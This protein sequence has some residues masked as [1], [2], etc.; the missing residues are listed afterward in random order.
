MIACLVAHDWQGFAQLFADDFRMS[1][2]R[3]VVQLELDRD[4]YVAFTREVADGRTVRG[5]SELLATRGERLAL[6]RSTFEFTDADVGPSEIAFLILTEVDARG[7]IVAYVRFDLDDLDAAYAELDA[8][9]AGR[10]GGEDH[11]GGRVG[12]ALPA[13]VRAA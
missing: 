9:W 4:R 7:R 8:R 1:D 10:R 6:T 11:G 5:D 2:R 3:R 13:G 12:A